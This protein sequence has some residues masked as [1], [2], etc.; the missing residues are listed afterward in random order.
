MIIPLDL[1]DCVAFVYYERANGDK[2]PA[3]TAFFIQDP[4]PEIGPE[5]T[6]KYCVTARHVIEN[7]IAYGHAGKVWLR[8]NA[9][10][11]EITWVSVPLTDWLGHPMETE[12][13]WREHRATPRFDISACIWRSPLTDYD[14]VAPHTSMFVDNK[15]IAEHNISAG[16]EVFMTGLFANHI[17]RRRNIPVVRC[18]NIAAMPEEPV[19]TILGPMDA[20]LIE[21]RSIGGLSGSPVFVS[22]GGNPRQISGGQ[23]SIPNRWHV[24]ILGLIHGHWDARHG[25]TVPDSTTD[26]GSINQGIAMVAPAS[27]IL[28]TIQQA[29][30]KD[31]RAADVR[32]IRAHRR[33]APE[34]GRLA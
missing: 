23:Y 32:L 7:V 17:G 26:G 6:V 27:H 22:I 5:A 14:V 3:G 30:F 12:T 16:D 2:A 19:E 18:G 15:Q 10:N 13:M 4:E 24:F 33:A 21:A 8:L 25:D 9:T 34:S 28:E 11:G 20:F 29:K 1:R 31:I